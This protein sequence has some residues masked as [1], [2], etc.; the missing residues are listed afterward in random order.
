MTKGWVSMRSTT[1]GSYFTTNNQL[2]S[3]IPNNFVILKFCSNITIHSTTGLVVKSDVA[4]THWVLKSSGP[5]FDSRV[6]Q[7]LYFVFDSHFLMLI[8]WLWS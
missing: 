5:G 6:V 8:I 4:S 2:I 3:K 7:L 1:K